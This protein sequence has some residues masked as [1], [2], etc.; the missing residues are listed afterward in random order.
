MRRGV[1]N[2]AP[3]IV[4]R[5][6]FWMFCWV[7]G[8]TKRTF[9]FQTQTDFAS[10]W[11]WCFHSSHGFQPTVAGVAG[12]RPEQPC[13]A[14]LP[15]SAKGDWRLRGGHGPLSLSHPQDCYSRYHLLLSSFPHQH[16]VPPSLPPSIHPE[17]GHPSWC[18]INPIARRRHRIAVHCMT[19][20]RPA[21]YH[22]WGSRH[23]ITFSPGGQHRTLAT[24]FVQH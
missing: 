11:H 18:T 10:N 5:A 22:V 16:G 14:R 4:C 3:Q 20:P 13:G 24:L 19:F 15:E 12:S 2:Q 17:Q 23:Y 6:S 8:S 9:S 7:R 1:A 21:G